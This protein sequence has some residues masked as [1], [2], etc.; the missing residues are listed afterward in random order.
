MTKKSFRAAASVRT[1]TAERHGQGVASVLVR[2][3]EDGSG[4]YIYPEG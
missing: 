1:T 2:V 4:G 3:P